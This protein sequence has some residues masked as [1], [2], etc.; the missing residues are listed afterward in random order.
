MLEQA[1]PANTVTEW[2]ID[3]GINVWELIERLGTWENGFHRKVDEN[4][5]LLGY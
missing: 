5:A 2:F 4:C 1:V 3:I